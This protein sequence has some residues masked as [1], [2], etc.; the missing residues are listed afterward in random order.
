MQI[1]IEQIDKS[2]CFQRFAI[3]QL[4]KFAH[5]A[6]IRTVALEKYLRCKFASSH[7]LRDDPMRTERAIEKPM[8]AP[9]RLPSDMDGDLPMTPNKCPSCRAW[10]SARDKRKGECPECDRRFTPD[11][12]DN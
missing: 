3:L 11:G 12:C 4:C 1:C 2:Q 7:K 8:S 5:F 10:L 6:R 9:G